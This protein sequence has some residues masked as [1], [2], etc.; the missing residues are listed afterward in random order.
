[1]AATNHHFDDMVLEMLDDGAAFLHGRYP[2]RCS[3]RRDPP[4][5]AHVARPLRPCA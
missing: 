1:M 5:F 4:A 3:L 2:F